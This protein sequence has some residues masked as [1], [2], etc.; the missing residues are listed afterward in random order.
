MSGPP[1][2]ND[3]LAALDGLRGIAILLVVWVHV[4]DVTGVVWYEEFGW[5]ML[6]TG[7][8]G[9]PLFFILSGL[10]LYRPFARAT[11]NGTGFP[12]VRHYF[13]RRALR[14]LPAYWLVLP[15]AFWLSESPQAERPLIWLEFLTLTHPY[16]PGRW[17]EGTS[18]LMLWSLSVEVC[19]YLL[20]PL[21]A[22]GMHRWGRGS[23]RRLLAV[24]S[25]LA[26]ASVVWTA[27]LRYVADLRFVFYAEHLLP[28]SFVHFALGMALAVAAERPGRAA[29]RIAAFPGL[30]WV[31]ALC[32]LA[33]LSTPLTTPLSGPQTPHQ[34]LVATVLTPLVACAAVAPAAIAPDRTFNRV[35]LGNRL[36][37]GCGRISYGLFLWHMPVLMAWYRLTGR[38]YFLGDFWLVLAVVLPISVVLSVLCHDLV[39]QPF[40]RLGRR[41]GKRTGVPDKYKHEQITAGEAVPDGRGDR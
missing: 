5:R 23:A 28:R 17:W 20:L 19:F 34:Y 18:L 15:V 40:Q 1:R 6:G 30:G 4:G 37:T 13:Q 2:R 32:G 24:L 22:R 26:V 29:A 14:I 38:P 11:L 35:L 31:A 39:E 25:G 27:T 9:V 41:A 8:I 3:H 36:L 7:S 33:L 12:D 21:L 16:D 10:L